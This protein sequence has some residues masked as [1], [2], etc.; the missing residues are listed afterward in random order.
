M[1][2]PQKNHLIEY[3]FGIP[4]FLVFCFLTY[5]GWNVIQRS[6]E[7]YIESVIIA[8][9]VGKSSAYK[10]NPAPNYAVMKDGYSQAL[11]YFSIG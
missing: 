2:N 10:T 11:S 9:E 1:K 3:L 8:A 6:N 5:L 4:L 7:V